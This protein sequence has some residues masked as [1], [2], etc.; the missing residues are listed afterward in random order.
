MASNAENVSTGWRHHVMSSSASGH[1]PQVYP[2]VI[3]WI[4]AVPDLSEP[5]SYLLETGRCSNWFCW[6]AFE[7]ANSN[8]FLIF[9]TTVCAWNYLIRNLI[10]AKHLLVVTCNDIVNNQSIQFHNKR[11]SFQ[12][13][14][15]FNFNTSR[16]NQPYHMPCVMKLLIRS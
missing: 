3:H 13:L 10:Y 1:C 7:M 14:T 16:A 12:L 4:K 11:A 6:R 9:C 15:I 8:I 2:N 5:D